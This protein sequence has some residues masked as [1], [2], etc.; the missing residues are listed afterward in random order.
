MGNDLQ[1]YRYAIGTFS[2]S[3]NLVH[4]DSSLFQTPY[5]IKKGKIKF[6][7]LVPILALIFLLLYISILMVLCSTSVSY[8][9]IPP[10]NQVLLV[11]STI[12]ESLNRHQVYRPP[13]RITRSNDETLYGTV[14]WLLPSKILKQPKCGKTS[15]KRY[16]FVNLTSSLLFGLATLLVI[17]S[18][19]VEVNPGPNLDDENF[20]V[21][22]ANLRSI[23]S[24]PLKIAE[25]RHTAHVQNPAIIAVGETWLDDSITNKDDK[26]TIDNYSTILRKDCNRQ[27]CGVMVYVRDDISFTRREEFENKETESIW[28][29][30]LLPNNKKSLYGFFY[31]TPSMLKNELDTWMSLFESSVT[32]A[33]RTNFTSIN[34]MGDLNAKN[35]I[36]YPEGVNNVAGTLLYDIIYRLGLTQLVREP[37]RI[38]GDS[39]SCIDHIITDTPALVMNHEVSPK[40]FNCDHCPITAEFKFSLP[41]GQPFTRLLYDYKNLNLDAV[42]S[43]FSSVPFDSLFDSFTN[44]NDLYDSFFHLFSSLVKSSFPSKI[45]KIDP[46]SKPWFTPELKSIRRKMMRLHK[47]QKRTKN[48]DDYDIYSQS[49]EDYHNKILEVVEV[50]NNKITMKLLNSSPNDKQFWKLAKQLLNKPSINSIPPLKQE[51]EIVSSSYEKAEVMNKYFCSQSSIDDEENLALPNLPMYQGPNFICDPITPEEVSKLLGSLDPGKSSGPDGIPAKILSICREHIAPFL[52][53]F[54]NLCIAEGIF[55]EAFKEANIIPIFKKGN[56]QHT[57]NYRPIALTNH[58]AKI[59]EKLIFVRLNKHLDDLDFIS[60]CQ[61]GFRKNDSTVQQLIKLV[62]DISISLDK[63]EETKSI[64][65]DISKAFDKVWHKGLLHKLE[66]QCGI[67]GNH[68]NFL[69]SYLTGRTQRVVV[70]NCESSWKGTSAGVPQGSVLG[71]L[72]FLIYINDITSVVNNTTHL[73][74]DDTSVSRGFTDPVSAR[75]DLEEDARKINKWGSDW[76]VK[77]NAAKTVTITYTRENPASSFPI[78]FGAETII[79]SAKHKHLGLI[80]SPSLSWL[81]HVRYILD[82]VEPRVRLFTALKKKLSSQALLSM[83]LYFIRPIVEYASPVW[84]NLPIPIAKLISRVQYQALLVIS[85]CPQGTN[86]ETLTAMYCLDTLEH[87][88]KIARLCIMFKIINDESCPSYLKTLLPNNDVRRSARLATQERPDCGKF[89]ENSF[90]PKTLSDW[91]KLDLNIRNA[92]SIHTFKSRYHAKF[93][94]NRNIKFEPVYPR[95]HEIILNRFRAGFTEL[96][97]DKHRHNYIGVPA[98]CDCDEGPENHFHFF[99]KCKRYTN[100]RTLL[101]ENLRPLLKVPIT[102][103]MR[104]QTKAVRLLLYS[105][106]DKL[107]DPS[108]RTNV[109]NETLQ[110]ILATNRFNTS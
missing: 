5:K 16:N 37:T 20:S 68:L 26:I 69:K 109:Q 97:A 107:V 74:A 62:H 75:L 22:Y 57:T 11:T 53:R 82:R 48:Q 79:D 46:R 17:L 49:R 103:I 64:Y 18:N 21:F 60:S 86:E 14:P 102:S 8:N 85:G 2:P 72:L 28:L 92:P 33:I 47:K 78:S 100:M 108:K 61:S 56:R 73:F 9:I 52:S 58:L 87:R 67:V 35:K 70:E 7:N 76:A 42:R 55:P 99:F 96:N 15:R 19:D 12:I 24:H 43:N 29:S 4:H 34:I 93:G 106:N 36:W 30:I 105:D 63:H 38:E 50:Y 66:R 25:L 45:I 98:K 27:G 81:D 39:K 110:Y 41:A 44:L 89:H 32:H 10:Q 91:N 13:A 40:L 80:L 84:D 51:G 59:F 3:S 6:F 77:F 101:L 83:Y 54:F 65:L 1:Q 94:V 90:I 31:R 88:R 104:P 95:S 71:P 23:T